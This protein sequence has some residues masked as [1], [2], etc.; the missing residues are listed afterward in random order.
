MIT[1]VM[2]PELY[3]TPG[4]NVEEWLEEFPTLI[5][6]QRSVEGEARTQIVVMG[7]PVMWA[8]P[9]RSAAEVLRL[10][11]E[12]EQN[13]REFL[14]DE[15]WMVGRFGILRRYAPHIPAHRV[16]SH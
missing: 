7:A 1:T 11:R 2:Y 9:G 14:P 13:D 16:K 4:W 5:A 12:A 8:W 15:V 3:Y 6:A 10:V